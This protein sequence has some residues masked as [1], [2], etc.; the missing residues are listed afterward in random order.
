[1]LLSLLYPAYRESVGSA[2]GASQSAI[3]RLIDSGICF[4]NFQNLKKE[5]EVKNVIS[6]DF[7]KILKRIA[8][9]ELGEDEVY[10]EQFIGTEINKAYEE[11]DTLLKD[12]DRIKQQY[13]D[14][15]TKPAVTETTEEV[16][17]EKEPVKLEDFINL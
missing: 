14:D 9:S 16:K 10:D 6:A 15:F 1:M 12:R 4:F 7:M 2:V 8:G 17:E 11:Y 5:S 3:P 13:I